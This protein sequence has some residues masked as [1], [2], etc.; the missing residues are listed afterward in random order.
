MVAVPLP[1][2]QADAARPLVHSETL[3]RLLPERGRTFL[4]TVRLRVHFYSEHT[5]LRW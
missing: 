2:S 4:G 5:G 1:P 3:L